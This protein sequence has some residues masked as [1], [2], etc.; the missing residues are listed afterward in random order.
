[1]H[2][3]FARFICFTVIG[4]KLDKNRLWIHLL[5]S[6]TK[7]THAI[8]CFF[9]EDGNEVDVLSLKCI[10]PYGQRSLTHP[11]TKVTQETVWIETHPSPRRRE[12]KPEN[13]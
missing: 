3:L 6:G 13:N 11:N 4:T 2:V 12:S 5:V 10:A 9:H 8:T 7:Y 1:M